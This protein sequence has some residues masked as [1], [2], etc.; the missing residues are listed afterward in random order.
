MRIGPEAQLGGLEDAS[1]V[2]SPSLRSASMAKSTIMI[3]FFFTIPMRRMIP[4]MATML[5]SVPGEHQRQ[6]RAHARGG[7]GGEDGQRVHVA[8]VEHPEHDVD[9]EQRE[10]DQTGWLA[11]DCWKACACR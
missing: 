1:R 2:D 5:R 10:D 11:S 8:L 9:G 6:E 4:M 7:Q 3:A